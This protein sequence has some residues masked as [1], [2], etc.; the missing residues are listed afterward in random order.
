MMEP[1]YMSGTLTPSTTWKLPGPLQMLILLRIARFLISIGF[2]RSPPVTVIFIVS[3]FAHSAP[4]S[5]RLST[6][7]I[8]SPLVCVLTSANPCSFIVDLLLVEEANRNQ[9]HPRQD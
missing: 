8:T 4:E 3:D 7:P 9:G 5:M 6:S 2:E 1:S